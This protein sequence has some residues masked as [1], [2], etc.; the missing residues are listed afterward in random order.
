MS[1]NRMDERGV[2][3]ACPACGQ[4]NRTPLARLGAA[5]QCGKCGGPIDS[6]KAPVEISSAQA[7]E[8][9]GREAGIPVVVDFWAPWC[10]P[11]RTVAPELEKV[12]AASNGEFLIAKIDTQALPELGDRFNVQ[13]IPT[14]AVFDHG[15]EVTRTMGARPADAIRTFIQGALRGARV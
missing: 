7:F 14:L 10:G 11:C 6:T 3:V 15:R 8:A 2:V 9:L 4:K 13:S 12:A 5:G 1:A